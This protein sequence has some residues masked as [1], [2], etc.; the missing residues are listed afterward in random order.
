M[1]TRSG[2]SL[3]YVELFGIRNPTSYL[4][5]EWFLLVANMAASE[6]H[7]HNW[8]VGMFDAIVIEKIQNAGRPASTKRLAEMAPVWPERS[9]VAFPATMLSR[10][11]PPLS[12]SSA[13][14]A[15]MPSADGTSQLSSRGA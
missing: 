6:P 13:M 10:S 2:D 8:Y 11:P 7:F 15:S 12:I 14:I 5:L 4:W 3:R 1:A 9:P